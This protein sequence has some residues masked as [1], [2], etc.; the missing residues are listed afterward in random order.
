MKVPGQPPQR[1]WFEVDDAYQRDS[2]WGV[3][4]RL[5]SWGWD[6]EAQALLP[7]PGLDQHWQDW[8]VR[9]YKAV[10][11][12]QSFGFDAP[13]TSL[14]KY[15]LLRIGRGVSFCYN[16]RDLAGFFTEGRDPYKTL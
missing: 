6:L 3:E 12:V 13:F 1:L 5:A 15:A 9:L 2:L 14:K 11:S 7:N 4:M 16:G 10:D 8:P